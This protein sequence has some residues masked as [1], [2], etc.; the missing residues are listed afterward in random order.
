MKSKRRYTTDEDIENQENRQVV[1]WGFVKYRIGSRYDTWAIDLVKDKD[2]ADRQICQ[3]QY[4][5][6]LSKCHAFDI[7]NALIIG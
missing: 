2:Q 5:G 6:G 1:K 4:D 7:V 3:S